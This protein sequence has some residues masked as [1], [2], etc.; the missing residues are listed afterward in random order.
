MDYRK[1]SKKI[2]IN[3]VLEVLRECGS[4]DTQTKMHHKVVQKIKEK[5][6]VK[7]GNSIVITAGVPFGNAGSTNLLRIAKILKE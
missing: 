2:I 7:P 5:D 6:L 1:P 4:I 3:A